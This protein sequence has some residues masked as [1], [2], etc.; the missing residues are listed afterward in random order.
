MERIKFIRHNGKEILFLDFSNC[1]VEELLKA[2]S[3]S[4]KIIAS[5]PGNSLLTLTDVTNAR[6][7]PEVSQKMK[8][9][10]AH[11][12]PYVKASALVGIVGLKKIILDGVMLF[13]KRKFH[14]FDTVEQAKDW[15]ATN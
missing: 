2:V 4:R 8:E 12:K 1:D 9:Y 10:A 14:T 7:N 6:F 11:N 5:R 15:L 13:S 3:A